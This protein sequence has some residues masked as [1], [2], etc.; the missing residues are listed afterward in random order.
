L[1][2]VT[3]LQQ[4]LWH[5]AEVGSET[6]LEG[7]DAVAVGFQQA[8]QRRSLDQISMKNRTVMQQPTA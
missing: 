6:G 1:W 8:A 3:G 2:I 5:G 4:L 7:D